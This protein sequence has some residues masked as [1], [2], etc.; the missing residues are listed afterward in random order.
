MQS[1]FP[2]NH[3]EAWNCFKTGSSAVAGNFSVR[4][5]KYALP[6]SSPSDYP[7]ETNLTLISSSP[8][9]R[10]LLII[11]SG[12]HGVE[13]FPGSAV[14]CR[15]MQLLS[16]LPPWKNTA[17]LLVHAVNPFGSAWLRRTNRDNIDLSRN[18]F[19]DFPAALTA[20]Q[21]FPHLLKPSLLYSQLNDYINPTTL[22]SIDKLTAK[23][24]I[25]KHG[26]AAVR[27]AFFIGQRRNSKG[28]IYGGVELQ[29]ELALLTTAIESIISPFL[30]SIQ[31]ILHF[32]LHT[33][34]GKQGEI[35][36]LVDD[37]HSKNILEKLG[38]DVEMSGFE[39]HSVVPGPDVGC[40]SN[41]PR[42]FSFSIPYLSAT[43]E[44]GTIDDELEVFMR[45]REENYYHFA[46][47]FPKSNPYLDSAVYL[48]SPVKSKFLDVFCPMD[49][50]WQVS[51]LQQGTSLCVRALYYL[52]NY[53]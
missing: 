51:V 16:D 21:T 33:G 44:F 28:L 48:N 38:I 14:Q 37:L 49:R 42:L 12:L 52:A 23:Y 4:Q 15:V 43:I 18:C 47:S 1:Y 30:P 35:L 10:N 46:P 8:Q 34:L 53:K 19:P 3:Y 31:S 11:S 40:F 17:L 22:S 36:T 32:D 25:L 9:P 20:Y 26:A 5:G 27:Q 6:W 41:L 39:G 29:P 50:T 2:R 24:L 7:L 45:L 13:L